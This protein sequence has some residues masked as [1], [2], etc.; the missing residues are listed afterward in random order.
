[1]EPRV[2]W[3][4]DPTHDPASPILDGEIHQRFVLGIF[5]TQ[6]L[7][8]GIGNWFALLLTFTFLLFA[9]GSPG[10]QALLE[11]I[12]EDR[13]KGRIGSREETIPQ[14]GLAASTERGVLHVH[15]GPFDPE[16]RGRFLQQL[17]GDITEW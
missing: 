7:P 2:G 5:P 1:M 11:V 4:L 8:T 16:K 6:V 10:L 9:Y 12:R 17:G 15:P 14:R 3:P 13:S